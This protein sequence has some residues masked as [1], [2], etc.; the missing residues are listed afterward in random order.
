MWGR[1]FFSSIAGIRTQVYSAL[2]RCRLTATLRPLAVVAATTA[3]LE[4]VTPTA[5]MPMCNTSNYL[6]LIFFRIWRKS[7]NL[8]RGF[9]RDLANFCVF[10]N[11]GWKLVRCRW[12]GW[13]SFNWRKFTEDFAFEVTFVT[14]RETGDRIRHVNFRTIPIRR[15]RLQQLPEQSYFVMGS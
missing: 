5:L 7:E 1:K 15:T 10:R 3:Q 11:F 9:A 2:S 13:R 6:C 12:G 4:T 8:P 14:A